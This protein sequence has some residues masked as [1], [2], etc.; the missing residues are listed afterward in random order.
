MPT[1]YSITSKKKDTLDVDLVLKR[2]PWIVSKGENCIISPDSD[3]LLC[4]LMMSHL[5]NWKVQGFYDGKVLVKN[6]KVPASSCIFLDMEIF[7]SGIRSVGQHMLLYNRRNTPSEWDNFEDCF[8]IN[9]FREYDGAHD[10]RLKY[11]FGTIHFLATTI[12]HVHRFSIPKS[13]VYPALFIDGTYHNLFRY[14]ENSLDWL[15]YLKI[16]NPENLFHH[17]FM[18]EKYTIRSLMNGMNEF[19]RARDEISGVRGER[20][21]RVAVSPRGKSIN[22]SNLEETGGEG[23]FSFKEDARRRAELFIGL[24]SK[25]FEWAYKS[26]DWCWDGWDV[27]RFTKSDFKKDKQRINNSTFQKLIDQNPLS[28]AMTSGTSYEYTLENPDPLK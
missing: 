5:F 4:G 7:R 13:A 12:H 20:G 8:S 6:R 17:I 3:G 23:I 14:T 27:C 2:F 1:L 21:D 22:P 25:T 28:F 19:W 16:D 10:F 11:P 18:A 26:D 24:L 9:N 15:R